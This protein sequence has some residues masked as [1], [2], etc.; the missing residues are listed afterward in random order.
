LQHSSLFVC[1]HFACIKYDYCL[2]SFCLYAWIVRGC[3]KCEDVMMSSDM[4][5]MDFIDVYGAQD[6]D[7]YGPVKF[8]KLSV[9]YLLLS[10]S[11][12]VFAFTYSYCTKYPTYNTRKKPCLF[13]WITRKIRR[14]SWWISCWEKWHKQ[15]TDAQRISYI[16]ET[17]HLNA[18]SKSQASN[19]QDPFS[20]LST[21]LVRQQ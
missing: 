2:H 10:C 21:N 8:H 9:Q 7:C 3:M 11:C 6:N 13:L 1:L 20:L 16:R 15:R 12:I 19:K 14:L 18:T 5:A 17:S 4:M